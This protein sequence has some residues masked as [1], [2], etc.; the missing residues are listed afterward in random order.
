MK[1]KILL[2]LSLILLLTGCTSSKQIVYFQN[3]D[4]TELQKIT[5]NYEARIKKDDML[6][7]VISGPDKTVIQPYNL[8]LTDNV[9]GGGSDPERSTIGY[10][11][12][13]HGEINFPILGKIKVEG[14]TR[15]ELVD[16]LTR[17]IGKDVKNPIVSITLKNYKITVL[18]EVRTPGTFTINSEKINILQALG[19]AGDLLISA[20]RDDIVLIRE[21]DGRQTYS[22]IN[23]KNKSILESPYFYLQQNDILYIPPSSSRISQGTTATGVWSV[24]LSS[25]T[26]LLAVGAL[27][28]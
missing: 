13:A 1:P 19:Y 3:L 11:V 2:H 23:M 17:E 10:L 20:K 22:K 28:F 5:A 15:S 8:T 7:I 24:V 9:A 6:S 12:D 4:N 14:M 21:I 18:G 25:I 27:I 16:Y 26:T